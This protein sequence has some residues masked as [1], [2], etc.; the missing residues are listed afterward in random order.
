MHLPGAK[1][2]HWYNKAHHRRKAKKTQ[3]IS[4]HIEENEKI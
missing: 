1:F 3:E 2:R 4:G